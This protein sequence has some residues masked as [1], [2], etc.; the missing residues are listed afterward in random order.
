MADYNKNYPS[1]EEYSMRFG[2][3]KANLEFVESHP[4]AS[5]KVGINDMSDWTD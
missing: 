3:F 4:E 5:F 2:I 1:T